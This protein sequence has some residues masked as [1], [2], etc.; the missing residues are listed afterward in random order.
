MVQPVYQIQHV[1]KRFGATQALNDVS[2]TLYPGEVHSLIGENGAGKSTLIKV[3][4]GIYQPDQGEI[5]L[6]GRTIQVR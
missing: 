4:T 2:L 1:S 5:L 3:M 6:D